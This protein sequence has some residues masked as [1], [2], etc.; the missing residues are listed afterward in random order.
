VDVRLVG[1]RHLKVV[2]GGVCRISGVLARLAEDRIVGTREREDAASGQR[3][4]VR[5]HL[6]VPLVDEPVPDVDDESDEEDEHG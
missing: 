4:R 2:G 6:E 1:R 5:L 3:A